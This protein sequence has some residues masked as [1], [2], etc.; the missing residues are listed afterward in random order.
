[1]SEGTNKA[2]V[3]RMIEEVWNAHD[4]TNFEEVV[5]ENHFDHMAVP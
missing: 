1:V 2:V 5:A 4:L 3:R